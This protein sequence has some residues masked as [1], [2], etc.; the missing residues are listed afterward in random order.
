MSFI[1]VFFYCF[2]KFSIHSR[3]SFLSSALH[4]LLKRNFGANECHLSSG[5]LVAW[6]MLLD[7]NNYDLQEGSKRKRE[8][9]PI[10]M[11]RGAAKAH[12]FLK[13]FADLP[14]ESMDLKQAL[15]QVNKLRGDLEKDAVNCNWLRQFL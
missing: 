9:D 11:S 12:K 10:D 8:C 13:D 15:Q 4:I 1:A 14:L 2:V 3:N 7:S 6:N 5:R